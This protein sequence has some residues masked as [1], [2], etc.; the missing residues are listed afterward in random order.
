MHLETDYLIPLGL[1]IGLGIA[2]VS[3]SAAILSKG[4]LYHRLK[5]E[6]RP[7]RW[8]LIWSLA[9]FLIFIIWF[10][11]WITWPRAPVSLLLTALFGVSLFAY[12][13]TLKWFA[14]LVDA[15]VKSKGWPLT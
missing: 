7:R 3:V 8:V 13:L 5:P 15:Y 4:K 9:L 11:V 12:G 1:L 10:P 6:S 2:A 14:H